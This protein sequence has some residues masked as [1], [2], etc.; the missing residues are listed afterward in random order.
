MG[1]IRSSQQRKDDQF[2][3]QGYIKKDRVLEKEGKKKKIKKGVFRKRKRTEA[4]AR[5]SIY[6]L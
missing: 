1:Y 5:R 6:T 3:I 4:A 2:F